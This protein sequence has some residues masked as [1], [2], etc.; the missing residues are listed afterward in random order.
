MILVVGATSHPGRKLVPRLID[1][2][3]QVRA[4]TRYPGK[5]QDLSEIGAEVVQ[6]DLRQPETIM[7]ACEG[8]EM[9]V[10]SVSAPVNEGDNNVHTIDDRGNRIL[11]DAA[12][13]AGAHH[14][15]F[16]SAYGAAA[17]H[18]VDLFR[19]KHKIE[20]YLIQSGMSYTILRPTIIMEAWKEI[21]GR[22]IMTGKK[23]NIYGSGKNP[24]NFISAD[25][26]AQFIQIALEDPRLQ[27]QILEIGGPDHLTLDE[28][29][30]LYERTWGIRVKRAHIP[31]WE[32]KAIARMLW[33]VR[34]GPARRVAIDEWRSVS[35]I[36]V[37][38][39]QT[40]RMYPIQLV[41]MEE[42]ARKESKQ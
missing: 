20:T 12:R 28:M 7:H 24:V 15:V 25:D 41:H 6:A 29:C 26:L 36:D 33:L 22:S 40:L 10:S 31:A 16:V 34:E 8:A 18:R 35:S 19:I 14:F 1:R 30:G 32:A 39:T 17:D 21:I 38:M 23:V 5:A 11:I 4:S 42:V 27:Q 3:Y 37:D 13:A 2:G 9:V